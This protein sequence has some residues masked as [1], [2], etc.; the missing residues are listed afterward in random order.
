MSTAL[1]AAFKGRT[2]THCDLIVAVVLLE[3]AGIPGMS[4]RVI[5]AGSSRQVAPAARQGA[6]AIRAGELVAFATETVYGVAALASDAGALDRLRKLKS[7]RRR[8]FTVHLGDPAEAGRYVRDI[9]EA[10]RR[11]IA[12][13]WPGPLTLLLPVGGRLADT[14]LRRAGMYELLCFRDVIGLRCP[15]EPVARAMLSEVR[16]P[17][18]ATSAN[19][20]G[21]RPARTAGE[22]LAKLD[23]RIDL[24]IDSGPTR[25]GKAST[26]VR[27][28]AA[29]WEIVRK[30]IL[31]PRAIRRMLKLKFLFVCTGNTC[32]SPMAAGLAR[33]MLAGGLGCEVSQLRSR[34]VEVVSAGVCAADGARAT[35][36]AVAAVAERGADISRHRSKKLTGRLIDAA[37]TVF[38]MTRSH[39]AQVRRMAPSAAGKVRRLTASG[40]VPDPIG[41]GLDVYRGTARQVEEALKRL[42]REGL[43]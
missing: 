15:D 2:C 28:D 10:A 20:P 5:Q 14:G 3:C 25:H 27:V 1:G 26:I 18:V 37:D 4:I 21:S 30:G 43:P 33:K 38:C 13:A 11:L 36:E 16:A 35:V 12:R 34:G 6:E 19:L 8:P 29:G 31:G 40:D 17:V 42:L 24:L 41:G 22:V 39:E 23:G 32:R 7:R 9:P